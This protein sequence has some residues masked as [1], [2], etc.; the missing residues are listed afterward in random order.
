MFLKDGAHGQCPLRYQQ[1]G[2][3]FKDKYIEFLQI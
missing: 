3:Y 1:R 2:L